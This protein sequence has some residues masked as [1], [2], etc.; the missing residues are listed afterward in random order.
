MRSLLVTLAIAGLVAAESAPAQSHS[1]SHGHS[2]GKAAA[3][4]KV[5]V[6][7]GTGLVRAIDA[8]G[9]NVTITHEPIRALNMGAMTMPF[10]VPDAAMLT[11]LA[12]MQKVEFEV[13]QRGDDYML[14]SIRPVQ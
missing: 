4:A 8:K 1:H 3:G 11:G 7:K 5:A 6:G 12:P 14:R 9:L 10:K 13:E 2:H